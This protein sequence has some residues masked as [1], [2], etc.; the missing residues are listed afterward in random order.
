[1]FS[2]EGR[3]P[4]CGHYAMHGVSPIWV[5]HKYYSMPRSL[6]H[7]KRSR[8]SHAWIFSRNEAV[9]DPAPPPPPPLAFLNH[10]LY[11]LRASVEF[12][13]PLYKSWIRRCK[14]GCSYVV[15][16]PWPFRCRGCY[17][18]SYVALYCMED[19]HVHPVTAT[20]IVCISVKS[21]WGMLQDKSYQ[22]YSIIHLYNTRF[23]I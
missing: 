8:R 5:W 13:P 7:G 3:L 12:A 15:A 19:C 17:G 20:Y 18:V 11:G 10:H 1:M 22:T 6:L 21:V 4:L 2:F 14:V 16:V 23:L 9:A